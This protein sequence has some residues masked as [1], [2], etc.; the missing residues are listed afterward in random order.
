LCNIRE[1][2]CRSNQS[3]FNQ[4]FKEHTRY[5][6]HSNPQ[7]AYALHILQQ[8]REYGSIDQTMNLLKPLSN[9]F[10]RTPWEMFLSIPLR[11]ELAHPRATY[12]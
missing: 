5:I 8:Q 10:L 7:S 6:R 12:R 2:I 9:I 3:S 11:H 1:S 4:R